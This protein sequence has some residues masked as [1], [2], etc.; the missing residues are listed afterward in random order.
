[1]ALT[2]NL[3]ITNTEVKKTEESEQS[4]D[5]LLFQLDEEV[6]NIKVKEVIEVVAPKKEDSNIEKAI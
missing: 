4:K 3:P 2:F 6:N 5:T 1:M